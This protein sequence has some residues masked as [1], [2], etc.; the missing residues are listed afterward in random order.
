MAGDYTFVVLPANQSYREVYFDVSYTAPEGVSTQ[1]VTVNN[2]ATNVIQVGLDP[3]R[4]YT[5]GMIWAIHMR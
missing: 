3:S 2:P 4:Q 5:Q 1:R